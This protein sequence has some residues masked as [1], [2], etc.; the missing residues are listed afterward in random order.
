MSRTL[1][2]LALL[3]SALLAPA[4]AQ[5]QPNQVKVIK[6]DRGWRL[7]VDGKDTFLHGVNWGYKPIGTNYSYD[8]WDQDEAFIEGELRKEMALLRSMGINTIREYDSMPPK[9]VEWI[10]D[11]YG[12]YTMINPL[13]GRYGAEIDGVWRPNTN[14]EDPRTREVLKEMTLKSVARYKDTRG[15]IGIMLGNEANYGLSW[16]SFEI[17]N[18]PEGERNARKARFLYSLYGEI[19]T[20][21]HKI[22]KNHPVSIC[23]GDLQY[24]DI[25]A[26]EA[27]NMDIFGTNVYRGRTARDLYKVVE[28]KLDLPIYYAEFGADAYDA[29]NGREDGNTQALYFRDQWEDV[30]LNAWGNGG[31]GNA[32]GGYSFQWADGWWK[33][34]QEENLD[35]HDTNASWSNKA[36]ID[37]WTPD[38]NNMNEEWFGIMAKTPPKPDGSFDLQPRPAYF[39]LRDAFK[40]DPYAD[41]TPEDIKAHFAALEPG[42]YAA[43]VAAFKALGAVSDRRVE[44]TTARIDLSMYT[45]GGTYK[46]GGGPLNTTVQGEQSVYLGGTVRPTDNMSAE[47]I[48]NIVGN[49]A[50]NPIDNI[51]YENRGNRNL[52]PE[53]FE[54][55]L[56]GLDRV[57]LYQ[58]SFDWSTDKV[59]VDGFYRTGHYHWG[60]EGD[61]WGLYPEANYGPNLDTYFGVAPIGVEL[62]G[63]KELEGLA[64]AVGPQL[65]WGA[66]PAILA[67]GTKKMLGGEWTL[68]HHED[69]AAANVSATSAAVSEQVIRRTGLVGVYK[70]RGWVIE[71]AGL[72]SGSNKIGQDFTYTVDAKEGEA[73]YQDSG[74]HLVEDQIRLQD[75]FGGKLSISRP[76][77]KTRLFLQGG[78]QG[79]VA[80]GG[81]DTRRNQLGWTLNPSGRG[82]QWHVNAGAFIP[83]GSFQIGPN[84]LVN[85]PLVGPNEV[86]ADNVDVPNGWFFP[87]TTGRNFR[88]DPFAVLENRETYGAELLMVYDP[89]PGSYFFSWDDLD[90]EDAKFAASLDIAY[91]HQPTVRDANFSFTGDGILFAFPGSPEARDE[92][93]IT[94]R[95]M[96]NSHGTRV[97]LSPYVAQQQSRGIDDRL[98]TRAGVDFTAVHGKTVVQGFARFNDWGPFDFYRDFNFTFPYQTMLDVSTGVGRAKL[99]SMSTRLGVRAKV[100]GLDQNSV[101]PNPTD[102]AP[103]PTI[104]PSTGTVL[105]SIDAGAWEGEILTYIR[106]MR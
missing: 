83:V 85:R 16:S 51:R 99:L 93:Q 28:E 58:A 11:N 55:S 60:F 56:E 24:I 80:D 42:D 39:V 54:G 5:A 8:F 73:S 49:V 44:L 88:D 84:V 96:I 97:V 106:V 92:W 81:Y 43:E 31:V 91:R 69:I 6:D 33:Y 23:N 48:V 13:V 57:Q 19:I 70:K 78:Y 34:K 66:N 64:V 101:I 32:I 98:V 30:Y 65:W 86:M 12:I 27:G 46:P 76:I 21:I 77:A 74:K 68:V 35:I 7:Q 4:A 79:L 61:V 40:L 14:Y 18:L 52:T 71:A 15:I 50:T 37:D 90:R 3:G 20:E 22:D 26:E 94:S 47:A 36:Y 67:R 89:T 82:N 62:T 100:R 17:E 29:K 1:L 87:G 41:D 25:I 102:L 38:G 53:G 103:A 9:W 75:T 95:M 72:F 105:N 45:V 2:S 59:D 10:Y 63:K 104:D